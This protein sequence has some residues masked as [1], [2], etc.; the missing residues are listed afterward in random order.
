MSPEDI[1]SSASQRVPR[2]ETP[3]PSGRG[4]THSARPSARPS[5][6]ASPTRVRPGYDW[7]GEHYDE[8]LECIAAID[9]A[10]DPK[11]DGDEHF[12]WFIA[13]YTRAITQTDDQGVIAKLQGE[14]QEEANIRLAALEKAE[15]A[16]ALLERSHIVL[17][18]ENYRLRGNL[19][20]L[21]TTQQSLVKVITEMNQRLA[22]LQTQ[23][24]NTAFT[25]PAPGP[26]FAQAAAAAIP[27][28]TRIKLPEPPKFSGDI[29]T[30][31]LED[32][33]RQMIAWLGHNNV[34]DAKQRI[35][36]TLYF[37]QGGTRAFMEKYY[38][39]AEKGIPLGTFEE[40]MTEL[41]R[42]Y[43]N[44]APE[45]EAQEALDKIDRKH[46]SSIVS[47]AADFRSAAI[48]SKYSDSEL[49]HCIEK[50]FNK[51]LTLLITTARISQ[52]SNVPTSWTSFLDYALNIEMLQ[53]NEM[54]K[55]APPTTSASNRQS[56]PVPM[57]VCHSF[58]SP[59][60]F[61]PVRWLSDEPS[62]TPNGPRD[63]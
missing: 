19:D 60:L 4:S 43:R 63:N 3:R 41:E 45:K 32:W 54:G 33:R 26:T 49:I 42:G 40:F 47:F 18:N 25:T 62:Y 10:R 51:D 20:A 55:S 48:R 7:R 36:F 12:L 9:A 59:L 11:H 34:T 6:A 23:L 56:D 1:L 2:P 29:K 22:T 61:S 37:L 14:L 30:L 53:R 21:N 39:A 57:D 58:Q 35:E 52:N 38:N 17:E 15:K 13:E 24:N 46:Y 27:Q 16:Y 31:S 5:R 44:L 50:K 28:S 8:V